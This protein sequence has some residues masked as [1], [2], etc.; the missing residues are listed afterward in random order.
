MEFWDLEV[1]VRTPMP[2]FTLARD[3]VVVL[4]INYLWMVKLTK[5]VVV[6]MN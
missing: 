5:S 4:G 6:G 1:E 3:E 2:N